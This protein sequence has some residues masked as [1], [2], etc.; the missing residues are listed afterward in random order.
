MTHSRKNILFVT[1]W[2][3]TAD[4]RYGAVYVRECAKA[5]RL[6]HNVTVLHLQPAAEAGGSRRFCGLAREDDPRLTEGIPT[7]RL[8]SGGILFGHGQCL[9]L[10]WAL[11]GAL[12]QIARIHGRVDVIHSH[13]FSSGFYAVIVGRLCGI[14]TVVTEH[15]SGFPLRGLSPMDR[16]AARITFSLADRVLPV[17]QSLRRA[18]EGYGLRAKFRVVPN[19]VNTDLFAPQS[20]EERRNG[21]LRLLFVGGLVEGKGL[22]ILLDAMSQLRRRRPDLHLD[23]IGQGPELENHRRLAARLG[24]EERA[25]FHGAKSREEVAAFFRRADLF[26]LPSLCETFSVATAEALAA[27]VPALVTRCGG[28]E[29]LVTEQSGLVVPPRDAHALASSLC[30]MLDRREAYD[31]QEIARAARDRFGYEAVAAA[32][33]EVYLQVTGST[34]TR[35][36]ANAPMWRRTPS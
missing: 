36:T 3:P 9:T 24:L 25:V 13:V 8:R 28:P 15:W 26:V 2:Y 33:D 21:F 34:K 22:P 5:V 14:P 4:Y 19:A 23:V 18:I 17:S 6:R 31:R 20:W 30:V 27:G 10:L 7:Y 11:L 1:P 29:E 16:I 32:M 12:R 35:G